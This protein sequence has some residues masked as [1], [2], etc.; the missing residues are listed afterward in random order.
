MIRDTLIKW[1][2]G[3]TATEHTISLEVKNEQIDRMARIAQ[4]ALNT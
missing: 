4:V 1:L 3:Y 2:G